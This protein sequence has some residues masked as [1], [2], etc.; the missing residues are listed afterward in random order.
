MLATN[1]ST[2]HP[3]MVTRPR[4]ILLVGWDAADWRIIH[5]LLDR[6]EMPTLARLVEGGVMGNLA[7]LH[8][9]ISPMLWNSIATGKTADK[10]GIH[11]F[12]EPDPV[13]GVRPFSSVSRRTKA[14]W[15]IFQ[16]ALGWRCNVIGWWAS[17]PAE[18]LKGTVVSNY[19]ARTRRVGPDR[20]E[21]PE[22][23]VHPPGRAAEFGPL[24]MQANEVTDEL[25]LPFIPRA[26]EID[27]E[28]EHGLGIFANLMGECCTVQATATAAMA[29][30]AWDFTAVYFDSIDHF[31]H[32]FMPFHPPRLPHVGERE[33]GLFKD[34]VN[35][36]YRLQ[37]MMLE[38][39]V[40]LAGPDALVVVCS[41][42]GFQ[43]GALR[44]LANPQ[45]PAGP[46]LWHRDFGVLVLHGPGVRR[47]ERIYGATLLDIVPTLLTLTGLPV[48]ADMDG[49]PL[50]D[51]MENPAA[52]GKIPSW[53]EVAG[54]DGRHPPGFTWRAS[55]EAAQEM[56]RQ[57]AAL[58]YVEDLAGDQEQAARDVANE[59]LYNLAQVYLSGGKTD[60]A[61]EAMEQLVRYRPWESR[62][63]H[64]LANAYLKAGYVRAADELLTRAYPADGPPEET[65]VVVWIMRARA[66]LARGRRDEAAAGLQV[67]M[68]HMVRH[69]LVWV[70]AGWLAVDLKSLAQAEACFRR[71][72]ELDP[73]CAVAWQGLAAVYVR[74]RQNLAAIDA[75]LEATQ[76][77]FHLPLAHFQLGVALAREGRVSP[78]IVALKRAVDMQPNMVL[79][80]RWLAALHAAD[81]ASAFLAGA[82]RNQAQQS[83]REQSVHKAKLRSRATESRALPDV[84][85]PAERRRHERKARPG[86]ASGE[87]VAGK[88]FVIV[89]G[90]P[91]SGTS[92]M[93][94][95]LAA[96]GLPPRTDGERA[97]DGDNPEGYLE[98]EAIKRVSREPEIFDEPGLERRAIKVVSAL[99]PHLPTAHHYRVVFMVRP[100]SEIVR[101]QARMI[102]RRGASG[103]GGSEG[104]IGAALRRH[105][106]ATLA[107]LRRSAKCFEVLEVD[108]PALVADPAPSAARVAGFL[109]ADLLPRPERLV[110]AVRPELRR[111][112]SEPGGPASEP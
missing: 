77:L 29:G 34:V 33:F 51:A 80:H 109:G 69:P 45:E 73:E 102:A 94:Q 25:I 2:P 37:D 16:Q 89:S 40:Q 70:E 44:P 78:A 11:G 72:V 67:A 101:S 110:D 107:L 10:H 50:L 81:G 58:G 38:R 87:V 97:A 60:V 90:L 18:P 23:S 8:P 43:S 84:P 82:H 5:P 12:T 54:D 92:L 49:K 91:R 62:Y 15:N 100:I 4:R 106:D 3:P 61:I 76:L 21:V 105:R 47:D 52:P 53:D 6:G 99:L 48:G 46:V 66:K 9:K 1:E 42:H 95:M 88:T 7:T 59:N 83:F 71:A 55:P 17:H 85:A 30:G 104:E 112:R 98:W 36:I 24:R 74:R 41:D 56:N 14:L 86:P 65:P 27:Q 19:F 32:S 103:A 93:M 13:A 57:F 68:H 26:A 63:L 79:A 75:G 22:H 39:L 96:G 35:G 108:Y 28:K 31:S 20:W 64:Q 111:Q